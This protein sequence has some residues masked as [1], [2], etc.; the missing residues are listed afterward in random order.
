MNE[1]SAFGFLVNALDDRKGSDGDTGATFPRSDAEDMGRGAHF[2][3]GE[4]T[5]ARRVGK[6]VEFVTD[7][8]QSSTCWYWK[9]P[10]G[11][12]IYHFN[13]SDFEEIRDG[14]SGR[15]PNCGNTNIGG[16]TVKPDAVG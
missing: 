4:V 7:C 11:T 15:C 6:K 14:H 3:P 8:R 5:D 2:I 9:M 13:Q 12:R 10:D 16:G 1:M